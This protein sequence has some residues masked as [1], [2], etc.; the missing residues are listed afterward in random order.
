MI[1]IPSVDEA[2]VLAELA[3]VCPLLT[4]EEILQI[5]ADRVTI[6]RAKGI[7]MVV[8]D[9]DADGAFAI[10]K[11]QSQNHNVKLRL[12]AQQLMD[13]FVALTADQRRNLRAGCDHVLFTLPERMTPLA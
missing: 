3:D 11:G 13:N 8:Y 10:L 6:E 1:E 9:V 12:V 2:A 4:P 5:A 7:L